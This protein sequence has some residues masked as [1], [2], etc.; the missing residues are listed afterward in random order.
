MS[1]LIVERATPRVFSEVDRVHQARYHLALS[2]VGQ[3]ARILDAACGVGYGA[4]YLATN[5]NCEAVT[6][7]EV[8]DEALEWAKE[9]FASD[10]IT[11][12]QADLTED[13]TV[14]LPSDQYD[15]I[16]CFE[17]LEHLKDDRFFLTQV[18]RLLKP[19]GLL[20]LSVPNEDLVPWATANNPWHFRH[21][22]TTELVE[23]M[24]EMGFHVVD[25]Y[26][27]T[28]STPI[29]RGFGGEVN[30][31]VCQNVQG[32][33]MA[34]NDLEAI[35]AKCHALASRSTEITGLLGSIALSQRFEEMLVAYQQFSRA[36][37]LV[38]QKAFDQAIAAAAPI[39]PALC[40]ERDFV[41][42][43]AFEG[44]HDTETAAAHYRA[45]LSKGDHIKEEL[46]RKAEA[47]LNAIA[48][49]TPITVEFEGWDLIPAH[50]FFD[51]GELT[52]LQRL[53]SYT[54]AD[55][56]LAP[57]VYELFPEHQTARWEP[58]AW[59]RGGGSEKL[60]KVRAYVRGE[61]PDLWYGDAYQAFKVEDYGTAFSLFAGHYEESSDPLD[62]AVLVRWL[63]LCLIELGRDEQAVELLTDSLQVHPGYADL[64]YLLAQV[65]SLNGEA[66]MV[67]G[68][69]APVMTAG[70]SVDYPEFFYDIR[71]LLLRHR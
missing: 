21:Y 22:R 71:G 43:L 46:A 18:R 5:S 27:Q 3:G 26:S 6:A 23:L 16:T 29:Y 20:L 58:V 60:E 68:L 63:A 55:V 4:Y 39:E 32:H 59:R 13:F 49:A 8:S 69:V 56:V 62:Q 14:K 61:S 7:V 57:V 64:R 37:E 42:G 28:W 33:P 1:A 9:H 65:L 52:K 45:L 11:F 54:D 50:C 10:K 35:G 36:V 17:T 31:V 19:G 44:K 66:A 34:Y 2:Y 40:P 15:L 51:A 48:P 41:L 67:E 38:S 53:L 47:R 12:V 30:V 25:G 24:G 70:D